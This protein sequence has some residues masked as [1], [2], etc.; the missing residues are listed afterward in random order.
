[1][2]E[3]TDQELYCLVAAYVRPPSESSWGKLSGYT[4]REDLRVRELLVIEGIRR[5]MPTPSSLWVLYKI[6]KAGEELLEEMS[7]NRI[8][9]LCLEKKAPQL[10]L[11]FIPR[12]TLS[13]LSE[14][15]VHRDR[16]IREA[17]EKRYK[18]L[19]RC[20]RR[21]FWRSVYERLANS[22]W[23]RHGNNASKTSQV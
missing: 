16:L 12:L 19:A 4:L 3:L 7:A 18:Q 2:V 11:P 6:A 5:P 23:I 17:A 22:W 21:G 1:M 13:E 15:T 14:V 10:A 8:V 9:M 20:P